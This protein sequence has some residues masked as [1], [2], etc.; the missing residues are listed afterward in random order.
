MGPAAEPEEPEV[1]RI[2]R[3]RPGEVAQPAEELPEIRR[4]TPQPAAESGG[5]ESLEVEEVV[6]DEDS[7]NVYGKLPGLPVYFQRQKLFISDTA[8]LLPSVMDGDFS[9]VGPALKKVSS[10]ARF[11]FW[12]AEWAPEL[13]EGESFEYRG[14]VRLTGFLPD[15]RLRFV[16]P[17]DDQILNNHQTYLVTGW[18]QASGFFWQPGRYKVEFL[19]SETEE[20]IVEW[21]FDVYR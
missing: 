6:E 15:G 7:I 2:E 13:A 21:E 18:G 4:G 17:G 8:E 12:A 19:S 9:A 3:V 20:V 16:Y 14:W 1:Q 10:R 11:V 5:G